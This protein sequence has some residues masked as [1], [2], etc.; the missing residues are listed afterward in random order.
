MRTASEED[1]LQSL[2]K[3]P[4]LGDK[5]GAA[6]DTVVATL[7]ESTQDTKR[8]SGPEIPHAGL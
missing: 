6:V 5:A 8:F 3:W 4:A 2:K 7:L 1:P